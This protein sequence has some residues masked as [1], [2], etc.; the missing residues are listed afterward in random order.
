MS[1]RFVSRR[2]K[3]QMTEHSYAVQSQGYG[4]SF[5]STFSLGFSK[6]RQRGAVFVPTYKTQLQ[7]NNGICEKYTL[8]RK[9]VEQH[10]FGEAPGPLSSPQKTDFHLISLSFYPHPLCLSLSLVN[11][12][13]SF[14][15]VLETILCFDSEDREK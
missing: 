8:V 2:G 1:S 6:W 4:R 13:V 10:E 12:V 7:Q 5:P 3:M 11:C 9:R 15:L 14:P